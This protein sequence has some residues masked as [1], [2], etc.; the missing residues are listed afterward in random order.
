MRTNLLLIAS[1]E[2]L[3][4]SWDPSQ[5]ILIREYKLGFQDGS[6]ERVQGRLDRPE[7]ATRALGSNRLKERRRCDPR[8]RWRNLL[9]AG[10]SPMF[11][12][13]N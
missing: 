3:I 11:G 8:R 5:L 7:L 9:E 12:V 10:E 1:S 6:R 13:G 4:L 2:R